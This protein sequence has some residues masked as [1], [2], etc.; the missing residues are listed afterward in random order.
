MPKASYFFDAI[1]RQ[2]SV[3]DENLNVEDN[4]E[5]Y[6]PITDETLQYWKIEIEKALLTGKGIVA[7]LGGTCLGDI[8]LVPGMQLKQ[9][10]GI[11]GIAEWYMSTI[12]R[13][14]YI[15]EWWLCFQY[16]A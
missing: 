9:P 4:L 2:Q 6:T 11:R 15:S 5:E 10:K 8:A 16:S 1:E 12:L 14:D 3:V 13:S 7:G